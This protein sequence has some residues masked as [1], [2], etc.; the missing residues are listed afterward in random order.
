MNVSL[1]EC[2]RMADYLRADA[3]SNREMA[4]LLRQMPADKYRVAIARQKEDMAAAEDLVATM[5]DK[6]EIQTIG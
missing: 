3:K 5:L 6:T 1:D 4:E 2:Q